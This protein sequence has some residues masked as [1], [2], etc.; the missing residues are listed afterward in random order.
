M[1]FLKERKQG[2]AGEGSGGTGEVRGDTDTYRGRGGVAQVRGVISCIENG[3]F[4][5]AA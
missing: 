5:A 1:V 3:P 4:L 2:L